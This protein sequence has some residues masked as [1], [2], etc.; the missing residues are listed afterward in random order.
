MNDQFEPEPEA[1]EASSDGLSD[2]DLDDVGGGSPHFIT[3]Y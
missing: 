1:A 3:P 2:D